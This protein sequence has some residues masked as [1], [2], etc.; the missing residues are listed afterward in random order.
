M[1]I[2][3]ENQ[4]PDHYQTFPCNDSLLKITLKAIYTLDIIKL[5]YK[6]IIDKYFYICIIIYNSL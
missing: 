6:N 3:V 5:I 4:D 2:I 1:Y